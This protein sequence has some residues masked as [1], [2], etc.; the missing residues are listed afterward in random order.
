[1]TVA[2]IGIILVLSSTS[3][4][5]AT[6][7][8]RPIEDWAGEEIVGW[9]DDVSM[10]VIQP[11]AVEW[12]FDPNSPNFPFT[13]IDWEYKSIWECEYQGFIQ[14][15]II[16]EETTLITIHI[17]V[18]EV[19]FMIFAYQLGYFFN[20]PLYHGIMKYSFQCR[21][22]FNTESLNNIL[23]ISGVIPSLFQIFA[24]TD[25]ISEQ[26][27]PYPEEPIPLVTYVHFVGQGYLT[28]GDG[29]VQVNQVGIWDAML[30]DF[31]WPHDSVIIV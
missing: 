2:T 1:M 13:L 15:R 12:S 4:Q 31:K 30:G 9:A 17:Q 7:T 28:D 18:E 8:I 19:P 21:I 27:W 6:T 5:G 11:H 25:P 24:A 22:L 20:P 14:E 26:Y 16:D 3:V 23:D 10:L 29:T